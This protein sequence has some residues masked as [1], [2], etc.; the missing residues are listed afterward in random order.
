MVFA[1][2]SGCGKSTLVAGLLPRGWKYLSDEFALIDPST[3]YL[4]PFPKAVCI[5]A[6]AFGI[7]R[8]MNLPFAG[9]RYYVKGLKGRVGYINPHDLGPGTIA[10]PT[11]VRFVIFPNYVEGREPRLYSLSRARAALSLARCG[12]NRTVFPNQAIPILSD[13]VRGAD[14]FRLESGPLADTCELIESLVTNGHG[15]SAKIA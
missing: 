12:L 8:R 1:G 14:C 13:V 3:L 7:V 10:G 4:R 15:R 2:A 9:R 6:G 5:K 11:P